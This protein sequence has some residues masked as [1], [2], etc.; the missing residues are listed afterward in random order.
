[1][2]RIL[3]WRVLGLKILYGLV[4]LGS[5]L[6]MRDPHGR[7]DA[8]ENSTLL[9]ISFFF[10]R[11]PPIVAAMLCSSRFTKSSA[12]VWKRLG[13]VCRSGGV[14][15][16]L[17]LNSNHSLSLDLPIRLPNPSFP[18]VFFHPIACYAL[19]GLL[20]VIVFLPPERS[21]FAYAFPF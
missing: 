12:K 13:C 4:V 7:H 19:T 16:V 10:S 15:E 5:P 3:S 11:C 18:P 2:S 6:L 8:E 20:S 1:M 17:E 14:E 21:F 9:Q